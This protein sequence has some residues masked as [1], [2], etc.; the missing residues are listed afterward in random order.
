LTTLSKAEYL[1]RQLLPQGRSRDDLYRLAM[2][3]AL[4]AEMVG[5]GRQQLPADEEE[6]RRQLA[7]QALTA[8]RDAIA[9]GFTNVEYLKDDRSSAYLRGNP[10]LQKRFERLVGELEAKTIKP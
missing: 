7:L 10:D 1:M 4:Q 3:D 5:R 8:L 6:Q 9:A 2:I